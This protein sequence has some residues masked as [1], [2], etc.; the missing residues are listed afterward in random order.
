[1]IPLPYSA[2]ILGRAIGGVKAALLRAYYK[3]GC[4][5]SKLVLTWGGTWGTC[6]VC[7]DT[8]VHAVWRQSRNG[9]EFCVR[10]RVKCKARQ[11]NA[12]MKLN[13]ADPCRI[14]AHLKQAS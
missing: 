9:S 12:A 8:S 13:K 10:P 14:G 5:S 11:S 3:N 1:M 6:H 7:L 2:L 4:K